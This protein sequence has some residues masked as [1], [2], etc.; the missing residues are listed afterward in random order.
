MKYYI[1][2][3]PWEPEIVGISDGSSQA[4]VDEKGFKNR[5]NFETF[6]HSF[7][8]PLRMADDK[9]AFEIDFDLE[10]VRLKKRAKLTD[11]LSFSPMSYSLF[12]TKLRTIL[13]DYR[14][15]DHRY[16][17]AQVTNGTDL[18][19]YH[20]MY[21]RH[22]GFNTIDFPKCE[23]AIGNHYDGYKSVHFESFDA[24]KQSK[25]FPA[26]KRIVL[27]GVDDSLDMFK[28]KLL[29]EAIVTEKLKKKLEEEGITGITFK[30]IQIE[31]R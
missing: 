28:T 11:V 17:K 2:T 13:S 24:L 1:A 16:F 12:S 18:Y 14:L 5:K 8:S 29:G 3:T 25:H 19:Q 7:G 9:E 26:R 15:Q 4:K 6:M 21:M 31:F 23:F 22:F 10:C 30:D 20:F 27:K